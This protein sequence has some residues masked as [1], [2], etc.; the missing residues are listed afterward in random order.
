[1]PCF[2]ICVKIHLMLYIETKSRDAASH[3]SVEAYVMDTFPMD[4]PVMMI[5][6]TDPCA[7]IGS[8]QIAEAEVD[9]GLARR[10]GIQI[11]RRSSGG[12]TIFTDAGT[13]LVTMILPYDDGRDTQ[14]T[15]RAKLSGRI[16]AALNKMGVAAEV[17]GRNDILVGGKKVS[18]LAQYIRNGK[19][20]SHGSLLYDADLEALARVLRVD[21]EKIRSKAL[22]SVRSRVA[23]IKESMVEPYSTHAFWELLKAHMFFG[24][25]VREYTLTEKDA[26][27]IEDIRQRQYGNPDWT[28]GRA[29]RFSFHNSKRFPGGKAD[30]YLDIIDGKVSACSIRGDFLGVA[31]IRGLE[32][33]FENK[34]F[35]PHAFEDALNGIA[36]RLYMGSIT[37][38]ELLSCIF[39]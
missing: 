4:E 31:P 18:G 36:L 25:D 11:V 19:I 9:L 15:A 26:A 12:G 23:N 7:M 8:N 28:F 14:Q 17:E 22:R 33:L 1:M 16:V 29:P 30:V 27:G 21:D 38:E 6:Q 39:G 32:E 5:W 37:K 10:A 24:E 3:F 34:V 20:C 2:S 35:Q 13:L